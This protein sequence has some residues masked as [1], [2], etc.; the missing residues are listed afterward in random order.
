SV[1]LS[2]LFL[3]IDNPYNKIGVSISCN[4]AFESKYKA[5]NSSE[6]KNKTTSNP[7]FEHETR[8]HKH[9][10][11]DLK[12]E[13]NQQQ[14]LQKRLEHRE[15]THNGGNSLS[16]SHENLSMI[17]HHKP[18]RGFRQRR[19]IVTQRPRIRPRNRRPNSTQTRLILHNFNL[20][21]AQTIRLCVVAVAIIDS[22]AALALFLP[23]L[24]GG[25][26]R[27]LLLDRASLGLCG[28]GGTEKGELEC[29]CGE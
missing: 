26:G 16:G 10:T 7:K 28:G 25:R 3:F 9:E 19:T 2:T 21:E 18:S 27:A 20:T 12:L 24:I 15:R 4:C 1:N 11:K 14:Q 22:S 17:I 5:T 8:K 29:V 6:N 23:L 13:P